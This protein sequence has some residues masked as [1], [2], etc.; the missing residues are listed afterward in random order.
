MLSVGSEAIP[1]EPRLLPEG[2]CKG[3]REKRAGEEPRGTEAGGASSA[4]T[5]QVQLGT[6]PSHRA[7]RREGAVDIYRKRDRAAVTPCHPDG[8]SRE[9]ALAGE[10]H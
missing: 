6:T 7:A 3:R 8:G 1:G 2:E 9:R 5:I 4:E 10:F